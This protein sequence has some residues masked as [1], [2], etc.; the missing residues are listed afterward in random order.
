MDTRKQVDIV[1][2]GKNGRTVL[3]RIQPIEGQM[4]FNYNEINSVPEWLFQAIDVSGD[5]TIKTFSMQKIQAWKPLPADVSSPPI[6]PVKR[7]G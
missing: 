2:T 4:V 1:Y 5:G 6:A 3:R 7:S